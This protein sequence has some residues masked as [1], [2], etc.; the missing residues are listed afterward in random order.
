MKEKVSGRSRVP[1]PS[2][3]ACTAGVL[4][5]AKKVPLVTLHASTPFAVLAWIWCMIFI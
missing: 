4:V 1:N 2:A 5:H 3:R